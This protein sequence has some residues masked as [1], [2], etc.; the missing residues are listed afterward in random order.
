MT[1]D[2]MVG[3]PSLIQ[4]TQQALEDGEGQGSLA[5]CSSWGHKQL[6]MTEWLNNSIFNDLLLLPFLSLGRFRKSN[7]FYQTPLS[8]AQP[9]V[10]ERSQQGAV[11]GEVPPR[12]PVG[13]VHAEP[14]RGSS[15]GRKSPPQGEAGPGPCG[16]LSRAR[17]TLVG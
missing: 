12:V 16:R 1:K 11:A 3:W 13:P 14:A 2:E 4:W 7:F 9:E 6:D 15:G 8:G 17:L 10:P 5:C